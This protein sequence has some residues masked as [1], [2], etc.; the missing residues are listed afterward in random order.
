MADVSTLNY[1]ATYQQPL[2]MVLPGEADQQKTLEQLIAAS[3]PYKNPLAHQSIYWVNSSLESLGI[4]TARQISTEITYSPLDEQVR[5]FVLLGFE[6]A[7]TEAQNALLKLLESSANQTQ[8]WLVTQN[9][10]RVLPTIQSRCELVTV[11]QVQVVLKEKS[12]VLPAQ[13]FLQLRQAT[14]P[15]CIELAG[16]YSDR[17]AA[18]NLV[19]SLLN[20]L[21]Q[22]GEFVPSASQLQALQTAF[23]RLEQNTN[24]KLALESA[25]FGLSGAKDHF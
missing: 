15:E 1:F 18:L 17:T 16:K 10:N 4:E 14:I 20:W 22:Q 9:L 7:T 12:E 23:I 13:I 8:F 25:F 19:T 21:T 3:S 2:L 5:I 6:Q 11:P 24:V